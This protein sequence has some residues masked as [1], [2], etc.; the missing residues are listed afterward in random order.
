VGRFTFVLTPPASGGTFTESYQVMVE[1]KTWLDQ[2][3]INY[4]VSV[5]LSSLPNKTYVPVLYRQA[6][7]GW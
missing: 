7:S 2:P 6:A 5:S 4:T 3:A 1:S